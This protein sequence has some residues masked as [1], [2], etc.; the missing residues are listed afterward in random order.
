MEQQTGLE[1]AL[2]RTEDDLD[3]A[4]RTAASVARELK[5]ARHAAGAGQLRDLRRALDAVAAAA[6]ELAERAGAARD[7]Y[8]VDEVDLLSS[9]SYRKEL[10]AAA[11][12]AGLSMYEEDERLLCYPSL[13]RILPNDLALQI[14]RR[15]ERRLRPSVVVESLAR[16]QQSGPRFKPGPFLDGLLGAYDFV[17]AA[18]G[19][20]PGAV[21]RLLEVYGALTLL[22]GSARD[23]SRQEFARD[24]Y[25]LDQSGVTSAAGGARQLRWA[26]STGTRQSGVLTTVSRS[27]QQ[28]RYWGV[29]FTAE[30]RDD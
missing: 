27:G 23:Y 2:A 1:A 29:S 15:R 4:A 20:R 11:A 25:L 24:L 26:A 18:Q 3:A 14:D 7:G 30:R 5:R 13:V 6:G 10:L 8:D 28:Q 19:K 9:G 16:A 17:V 21:V 12:E 22:P